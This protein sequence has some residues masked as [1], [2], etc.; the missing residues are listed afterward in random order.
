MSD[1]LTA[2]KQ[3]IETIKPQCGPNV[4]IVGT[5]YARGHGEAILALIRN[6]LLPPHFNGLTPHE[7]ERLA[8]LMEE[9]AEVIK[10]IGKIMRHGYESR[11]PDGGP[12]NRQMLEEECGHVGHA[13]IRLCQAGDLSKPAIHLHADHK[14][15]SVRRWLHHQE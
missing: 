15:E 7:D 10:V 4:D 8:L 1:S 3:A 2:L 12:T 6:S 14:A 13:M 11:H 5:L 9:C